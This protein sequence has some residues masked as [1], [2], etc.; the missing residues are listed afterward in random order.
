MMGDQKFSVEVKFTFE[1]PVFEGDPTDLFEL[2]DL[3]EKSIVTALLS[4]FDD[5]EIQSIKVV[6]LKGE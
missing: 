5:S 3:E 2:A 1:A 4:Q 6:A